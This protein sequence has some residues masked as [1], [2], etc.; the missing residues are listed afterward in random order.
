MKINVDRG[1]CTGIGICES[2]APD[3]FEVDDDGALILSRADVSATDHDLVEQAVRSCPAQ[4]L[5]IAGTTLP[6][7]S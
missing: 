3:Y 6:E 2:V 5:S 1:R 7:A 4:A